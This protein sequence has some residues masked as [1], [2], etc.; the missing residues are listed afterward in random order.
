MKKED[1]IKKLQ[2]I[3]GNP[4]VAVFDMVSSAIFDTGVHSDF[5]VDLIKLEED[6]LEYFRESEG[7]EFVPWIAL[8][9]EDESRMDELDNLSKLNTFR[10]RTNKMLSF[11]DVEAVRFVVYENNSIA[12]IDEEDKIIHFFKGLVSVN[13]IVK[14]NEEL[15]E[16]FTK[17]VIELREKVSE[18]SKLEID[19]ID[20][21]PFNIWKR[22]YLCEKIEEIVKTL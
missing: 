19:L 11:T 6:E 14:R 16:K 20:T 17:K 12:F 7:E 2:A 8:S 3:P 9:F 22:K 5:G 13:K 1:L 15:E 21:H 18:I 10:V 4:N